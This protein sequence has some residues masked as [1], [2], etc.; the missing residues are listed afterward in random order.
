MSGSKL[1]PALRILGIPSA[2]SGASG[3]M[4]DKFWRNCLTHDRPARSDGE[5][6]YPIDWDGASEVDWPDAA[7]DFMLV[8]NPD[9][10]G[11]ELTQPA[12]S[13]Q[14]QLHGSLRI[15]CTILAVLHPAKFALASRWRRERQV[16]VLSRASRSH[17][18][19]AYVL[20]PSDYQPC[21][22]GVLGK[23]KHV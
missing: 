21:T 18:R 11:Y 17:L 12:Q 20:A 5:N 19:C 4:N 7:D 13:I 8:R 2:W 1:Q 22:T 9:C 15:V 14:S 16:A 3:C 10:L 23:F 6:R